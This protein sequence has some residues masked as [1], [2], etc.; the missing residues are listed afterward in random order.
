MQSTSKPVRE[1]RTPMGGEVAYV[2]GCGE[3]GQAQWINISRTG[4]AVVLGRYLRPG[5]LIR[6]DTARASH[7]GECTIPA[8]VA[9]CIPAPGSLYF[10]AG[11]RIVRKDPETAL[12]FASL[13]YQATEKNK[14]LSKSVS[15]AGWK[16][17]AKSM[18]PLPNVDT[19]VLTS[20]V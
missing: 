5:R 15:E 11:L 14:T 12:H 17:L 19:S 10:H 18:D 13:A 16:S 9:W 7:E 2:T 6:L 4:A 20:A 1:L 8:E 3:G